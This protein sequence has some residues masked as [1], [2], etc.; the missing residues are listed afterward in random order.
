MYRNNFILTLPSFSMAN[1]ITYFGL[2][3]GVLT[4][5]SFLPQVIKSLKTKK[6]G[7]VSVLMYVVLVIG[8]FLW[9][10]YGILINDLPLILA[11]LITFILTFSVLILK[12]RH[13]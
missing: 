13:G 8:V 7:D 11:N 10:I 6:T 5:I 3:A 4:T 1:W 9:M 12:L 2:I